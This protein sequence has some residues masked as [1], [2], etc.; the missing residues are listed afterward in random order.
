MITNGSCA[1]WTPVTRSSGVH[2][3]QNGSRTGQHTTP[4]ILFIGSSQYRK[5]QTDQ[6]DRPYTDAAFTTWTG[7]SP[8]QRARMHFLLKGAD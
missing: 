2:G 6:Q 4:R 7:A 5:C 3:Q 8:Q 1:C